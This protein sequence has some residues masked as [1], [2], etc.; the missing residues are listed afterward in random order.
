MKTDTSGHYGQSIRRDPIAGVRH[1]HTDMCQQPRP[2]VKLRGNAD[3]D[4]QDVIAERTALRGWAKSI[5][6]DTLDRNS[7]LRQRRYG[8]ITFQCG[9][10]RC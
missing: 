3:I 10:W 8:S 2:R 7:N 4:V 6:S 9:R 5:V 1:G